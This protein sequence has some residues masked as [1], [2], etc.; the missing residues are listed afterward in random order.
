VLRCPNNRRV[1]TPLCSS[2]D[3]NQDLMQDECMVQGLKQTAFQKGNLTK[4]GRRQTY[5]RSFKDGVVG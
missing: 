4:Q 3:H 1:Q 2:E 5:Q